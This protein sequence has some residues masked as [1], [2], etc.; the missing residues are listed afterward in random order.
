M[1]EL[2]AALAGTTGS[3]GDAAREDLPTASFELAEDCLEI[4]KSEGFGEALIPSP[5]GFGRLEIFSRFTT[6]TN[7]L[8]RRREDRRP[9]NQKYCKRLW[10]PTLNKDDI[11]AL[12]ITEFHF[13]QV[14]WKPRKG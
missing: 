14:P 10:F 6:G 5:S 12:L 2:P 8:G 11:P 7:K 3:F 9:I 13:I 1:M 4:A